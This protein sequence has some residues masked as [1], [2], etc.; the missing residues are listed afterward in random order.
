MEWGNLFNDGW[1]FSK[2]SLSDAYDGQSVPEANTF[3]PVMVPHDWLI[4]DTHNLYEDSVGWYKKKF[5]V[6][7]TADHYY[8]IRFDG[9]YMDSTVYVNGIKIGD[10]KYGYSAF[11]FPISHALKDGVNE[12]LVRVFHQSTNSRWY[13]GAGIFRNVWLQ[14]TRK[15]WLVQDGI[16]VSAKQEKEGLWTVSLSA[17]TGRELSVSDSDKEISVEFELYESCLNG[18]RS[19]IEADSVYSDSQIS[20]YSQEIE[21]RQSAIAKTVVSFDSDAEVLC[22]EYMV[23]ENTCILKKGIEISVTEPK[24]WNPES[25]NLYILKVVLKIDEEIW[26]T[27]YARFGFRKLEYRPDS[28]FWLNGIHTK[29]NGTC[30]HHD[31]GCLGA[32]YNQAAMRRKFRILQ[33]MGVNAIRTAHNMQSAEFMDLADEHG[34]LVDSEGFDMWEKP[35]NKY[36]YARFFKEWYKKDVASWIRRDRN[37]PSVI[38]WSIGNEIYDTHEDENGQRITRELCRE[39]RRYDFLSDTPMTIGSNYMPWENAQKCADIVKLAGYNYAEKYYEDHHA[40]HPDWII[41][42]SETASHAQ[43][44]GIYHFPYSKR[45]LADVDEQC[46]ALGN[47]ATSWGAVSTEYCILAE[48]DHE[49]SCGQFLWSG[50]DYIGEPTPY[51]T[52]NSYLGQIDTAGFPK[53]AYYIYQSEWKK[54]EKGELLHVFPYWDFN[55][56][57][58]VDV[59]AASNADYLEL[60]VNGK[61]QGMQ[62]I[63]HAHDEKLTGDWRVPYEPGEIRV[64]AYDENRNVLNEA[65]KRSFGNAAKIVCHADRDSFQADGRDL[66]FVEITMEDEGGNPVE[67]ANNRVEITVEGCGFLAGTDNGDSTD[68]DSYKSGSRRL[69]SGKLLA[70]IQAGTQAGEVKIRVNSYGMEEQILTFEAKGCEQPDVSDIGTAYETT[71]I[72]LNNIGEDLEKDIPVR[73]IELHNYGSRLLSNENPNTILTAHILPEN[74]SDKELFWNVVDDGGIPSNLAE[75]T[76]DG[77]R[78]TVT[79]KGDGKFRVRCMTK[80]GQEKIRKISDMDFEVTGMG[81]AYLDPYGFVNGGLY[82]YVKGTPGNGNEYGVATARDGETQVGYHNLDFGEKG[83]DEI[84]IPI[85]ALSGDLYT[86]QIWEGMPEEEGSQ[87]VADVTYQKPCKWNVYQPET[88]HL[89]KKLKGITSLCF[90]AQ[91]KMHIKGFTFT[92][93]DSAFDQWN[94]TECM[95]IY[96]D[97]FRVEDDAVYEIG[98]NVTL[99]FGELDFGEKGADQIVISGHSPIPQ[100]SINIHFEDSETGET[101]RQIVEFTQNAE[102]EEKICLIQ[103]IYGKKK[104]SFVFLPGSNFDF[105]WFRFV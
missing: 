39:V 64:I 105:E 98:N 71:D 103:P 31:M 93:Q 37:H 86:L 17:E 8:F 72:C 81:P 60:F 38:M 69:F 4:Y 55:P 14:E 58:T 46:S 59:R 10:W 101:V 28:G 80:N 13:S 102:M 41:Y 22:T 16:Y 43:S 76:V 32:V 12:I 34:M 21:K 88:Y 90:V 82:T 11:S 2:V 75:L 104:V 96:G 83:S 23:P 5:V 94:A 89:N 52:K 24:L 51:H 50:F 95:H 27:E 85:F 54:A 19:L 25:P 92:R 20:R 57:Q 74:A 33:G 66:I 61:S 42:G 65:V 63:D 47:S 67:N 100:N 73:K 30:E 44:R 36:D 18:K 97:C 29:L 1:L 56:G 35:K 62:K 40:A 6:N 87:M 78:V 7:N 84:T 68:Y 99:D 48:R 77:N 79:A 3:V 53:D 45:M 70:V 9:V 15:T 26:Q 91:K 49:Y